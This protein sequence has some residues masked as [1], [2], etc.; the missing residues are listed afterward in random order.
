MSDEKTFAQRFDDYV[1]G[2]KKKEASELLDIASDVAGNLADAAWKPSPFNVIKCGINIWK[3]LADTEQLYVDD[4]FVPDWE[5]PFNDCFNDFIISIISELPFKT[6]KTTEEERIIKIA[7]VG[8][9]EIAWIHVLQSGECQGIYVRKERKA[10]AVAALKQA[11]WERV[12]HRYIVMEK[13]QKGNDYSESIH[14]TKDEDIIGIGSKK[15]DEYSVYLKKCMEA[16]I[17]RTILFYGPPGTGKSTI[18]RAISDQLNLRTLRIR[19]EDVGS[20]DN[21]VIFEAIDIFKPDAIILDD[22]D[23]AHQQT[24]L[25]ETMDRFH[26]HLKFVFATVNHKDQLDDALLRPG[27]FD[28]IVC[29]KKLDDAVVEKVC[30][31]ILGNTNTHLIKK[32]KEWPIA[33]IKEYVTRRRIMTEEEALKSVKEL[34]RRVNKLKEYDDYSDEDY[35]D[36]DDDEEEELTEEEKIEEAEDEAEQDA[37]EEAEEEAEKKDEGASDAS[38]SVD[39]EEDDAV[40]GSA[41][42]KARP[43]KEKE[44]IIPETI[45]R[46]MKQNKIKFKAPR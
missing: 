29:I 11:Q 13:M 2:M 3:L 44:E 33:F 30:A 17:S 41:E 26:K 6:I 37:E 35:E 36:E 4:Y 20:I 23:R 45:A 12:Q 7:Q 14:F 46:L 24:H 21:S 18:A 40:E 25:L 8:G 31:D 5:S 15:A 34:T 1:N 10:E 43:E 28:E 19:V 16:G 42:E 38:D 27:R 32:M 22:L 9:E 39:E